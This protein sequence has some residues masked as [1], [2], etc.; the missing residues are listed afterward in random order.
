MLE[1]KERYCTL[2]EELCDDVT[3]IDVDELN[4]LSECDG[5]CE[6]CRHCLAD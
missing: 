3:Q 1:N 2:F 6:Y 5:E 4:D